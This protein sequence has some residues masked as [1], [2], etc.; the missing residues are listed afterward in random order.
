MSVELPLERI[1]GTGEKPCTTLPDLINP[2]EDALVSEYLCVLSRSVLC[3]LAV[4]FV[5]V[6]IHEDSVPKFSDRSELDDC[7]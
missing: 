5:A 1:D 4:V 7:C 3:V 2:S 6:D